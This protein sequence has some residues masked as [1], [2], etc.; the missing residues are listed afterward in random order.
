MRITS[1]EYIDLSIGVE[2]NVRTPERKDA[3]CEIR[4]L[5]RVNSASSSG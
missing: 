4:R 1:G 3:P 5:R 2:L